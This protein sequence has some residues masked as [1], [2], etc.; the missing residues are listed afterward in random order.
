MNAARP[1]ATPAGNAARSALISADSRAA[2]PRATDERRN[3]S[4]GD[5]IA[6]P[7]LGKIAAAKRA[8]II[9]EIVVKPAATIAGTS[10]SIAASTAAM[11]A[12][13][14]EI[15]VT[16]RAMTAEIIDMTPAATTD[17]IIVGTPGMIGATIIATVIM[18]AAT[19]TGGNEYRYTPDAGY[20][21]SDSFTY[22]AG[23]G[24]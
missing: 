23:D 13:T 3:A 2:T 15:I 16:M 20:S 24:A 22:R 11:C 8:L 1:F 21:G 4:T 12:M 18:I 6:A 17:A 5:S 9:A 10:V 14:D 19:T 7:T